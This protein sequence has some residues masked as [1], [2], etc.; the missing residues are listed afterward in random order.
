M[1]ELKYKKG[2]PWL[3]LTPEMKQFEKSTGKSAVFRG[4]ITG[5]F[6][7]WLWQQNKPKL[8]F[9]TKTSSKTDRPHIQEDTKIIGGKD[10]IL[11]GYFNERVKAQEEKVKWTKLGWKLYIRPAHK[12]SRF[13]LILWRSKEKEPKPKWTIIKSGKKGENYWWIDEHSHTGFRTQSA[14]GYD[15]EE[16]SYYATFSI[17]YDKKKYSNMY[18]D[19]MYED[20]WES[21]KAQEL[22]KYKLRDYGMRYQNRTVKA[23]TKKQF[24]KLANY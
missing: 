2:K 23:K 8:K 7:Y 12:D 18:T 10:Y 15:E 1:P 20:D 17:S 5:Q 11:L 13:K 21:S 3:V 14:V 9:K 6:E 19:W 24:Y 4:K 16:R 22:F